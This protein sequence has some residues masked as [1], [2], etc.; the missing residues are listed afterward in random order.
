VVPA[1][2]ATI[3]VTVFM[4]DLA[5]HLGGWVGFAAA[6][7]SAFIAV[8]ATVA[9]YKWRRRVAEQDRCELIEKYPLVY[10]VIALPTDTRNVM[11]AEGAE[12]EVGD[13]GWEAE[14]LRSD[15][16]TYLHG[17]TKE[18][19]VAWYAGFQKGQIEHVGLK[20]RSQYEWIEDHPCPY[21][22][23][24]DRTIE[25]LGLGSP[26]GTR[27]LVRGRFWF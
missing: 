4:A 18:W 27:F 22:I 3:Y 16:L 26:E 15:G 17:L 12:I 14:P 20:P 5:T 23:Q 8:A 10:R 25:Y 13:Y 7:F 24:S 6:S 1:V 21:P 9:F 19:E 11:K 2:F